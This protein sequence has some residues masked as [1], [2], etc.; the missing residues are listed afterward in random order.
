MNRNNVRIWIVLSIG[1]S[2]GIAPF[3]VRGDQATRDRL[4]QNRQAITSMTQSE[5]DRLDRNFEAYKLMDAQ[6]ISTLKTFHQEL[7]QQNSGEWAEM[8]D[9]YHAWLETIE[10]YQRDKLKETTDPQKRIALMNEIIGEQ[11]SRDAARILQRSYRNSRG[12]MP[13]FIRDAPVL[14]PSNFSNLMSGLQESARDTLTD[15]DRSVLQELEGPP[16]HF[17]L[18]QLIKERTLSGPPD[19]SLRESRV[20]PQFQQSFDKMARVFD[21]FVENSS[22]REYI[23][24][25]KEQNSFPS[26]AMRIQIVIMKTLIV[27]AHA[28]RQEVEFSK[29]SKL[30]DLFEKLS[31]GEQDELLQ[32]EA[33][34]FYKELVSKRAPSHK[35][36]DHEDMRRLFDLNPNK[37]QPGREDRKGNARR[38][39]GDPP[40]D[41]DNRAP[42]GRGPR[43]RFDRDDRPAQGEKSRRSPGGQQSESLQRS[44]QEADNL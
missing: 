17:R 2:L 3:L 5:R 12:M 14:S 9:Q 27:Q 7:N 25:G 39:Q 37:N 8:L 44:R 20:L 22:A 34:D 43:G 42:G 40:R 19:P 23:A 18:L 29:Q 13:R 16:R 11:R 31:E 36:F 10:P 4:E 1:I 33:I 38:G 26:A 21:S 24:I 35:V 30:E 32:L 28:Q 15:Q 41:F 6:E